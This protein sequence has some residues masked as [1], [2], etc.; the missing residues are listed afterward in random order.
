[1]TST[2]KKQHFV[3][4]DWVC[5]YRAASTG[6]RIES[7][8]GRMA[9]SN[10]RESL[11]RWFAFTFK[12]G[13]S[14]AD[15]LAPELSHFILSSCHSRG[16][17]VAERFRF[18]WSYATS[19]ADQNAVIKL[20]CTACVLSYASDCSSCAPHVFSVSIQRRRVIHS[21]RQRHA[22]QAVTSIHRWKRTCPSL[23]FHF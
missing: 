1:M 9:T 2:A 6:I 3:I 5:H 13:M 19:G 18:A 23:V 16:F 15:Q 4:D 17:S 8:E 21:R 11:W 12:F 7:Q 22:W 20:W 10:K 14:L